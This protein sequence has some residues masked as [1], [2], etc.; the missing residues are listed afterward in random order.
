MPF[1]Y[2][3]LILAPLFLISGCSVGAPSFTMA[4]SYFPA[5]LIFAFVAII[6]TVLIRIVLIRLGI[7]DAMRF[8]LFI[9]TALAL[10]ICFAALWLFFGA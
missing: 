8:K 10:G 6:L 7:D 3:F 2:A 4:G 1:Y 9:Y 5:W